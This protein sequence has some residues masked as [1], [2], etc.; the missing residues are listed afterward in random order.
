QRDANAAVAKA[1]SVEADA[2]AGADASATA[3][4][5]ARALRSEAQRF[6]QAARAIHRSALA[7]AR[8]KDAAA[9]RAEL[10]QRLTI[11]ETARTAAETAQAAARTGPSDATM[12]RLRTLQTAR[13]AAQL[14]RERAAPA[15]SIVYAGTGRIRRDGEDLPEGVRLPL[16]DGGTFDLDGIGRLTLHPGAAADAESVAKAEADLAGTLAQAGYGSVREAEDA[17]QVRV[18]AEHRV[19]QARAKLEAA[20]PDGLDALHAALAALPAHAAPDPALPPVDAA[21]A[22]EEAAGDALLEASATFDAA[23][24]RHDVARTAHARADAEVTATEGRAARAA[25]ALAVFPDPA[26]A[27]AALETRLQAEETAFAEA[28]R[29]LE[30]L[31]ERAPDL[32]AL[33]ARHARAEATVE[34]ARSALQTLAIDLRGLD[35]QIEERASAGIE[36]ELADTADTLAAARHRLA[37]IQE[38]CAVLQRLADA[39]TSARQAAQ[40]HYLAPVLQELGPLLRMLW[41]E[42]A[43]TL[44]PETLL[45]HMLTRRETAEPFNI[46]SGGT[47]EQIALLV[48][49]AFARMLARQGR[50]APVILDDAIVYADDDRIETLFDAL[51]RQAADLQILVFSCRQRAFRDLGGHMLTLTSAAEDLG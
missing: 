1:Q 32:E 34:A 22:A 3:Y 15:L 47:R 31:E 20:A 6:E 40:E 41:P 33:R 7:A 51:T 25:L 24:H 19:A 37:A 10:S 50:P 16:P 39:L 27:L 9:R 36:E 4:E 43:L 14:A 42:A 44:D 8:A 30:R 13:D 26:A 28:T 35:T 12:S 49:L 17:R 21:A 23:R 46:L 5:S 29:H 2:R 11:A 48:R 38:E 18:E 45:P